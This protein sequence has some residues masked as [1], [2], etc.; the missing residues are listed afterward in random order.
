MH[1]G[2]RGAH[3]IAAVL[4]AAAL[5]SCGGGSSAPA[6]PGVM[7]Q[8]CS[9]NNPYRGDATSQIALGNISTEKTWLRDYIDRNYLWFDKVPAV[10]PAAALVQQ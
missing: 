5:T 4:A 3:A 7:A 1:S 2:F 10:N 9:P 6:N 8:T